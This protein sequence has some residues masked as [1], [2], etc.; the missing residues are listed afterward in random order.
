[1]LRAVEC[2]FALRKPGQWH[3]QKVNHPQPVAFMLALAICRLASIAGFFAHFQSGQF[4]AC[5]LVRVLFSKLLSVHVVVGLAVRRKRAWPSSAWL[6]AASASRR[7]FRCALSLSP[8]NAGIVGFAPLRL[9]NSDFC[10][11]NHIA[12]W[13]AFGLA[14]AGCS[15]MPSSTVRI[16]VSVRVCRQILRSIA[17]H[18]RADIDVRII[19]AG[20]RVCA[21]M[22]FPVCV[23]SLYPHVRL[24][25]LAWYSYRVF[26]LKLRGRR[27]PLFVSYFQ[28]VVLRLMPLRLLS[29]RFAA[30]RLDELTWKDNIDALSKRMPNIRV[31]HSLNSLIN[32]TLSVIRASL[33]CEFASLCWLMLP[34]APWR[35]AMTGGCLILEFERWACTMLIPGDLR[36]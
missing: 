26:I 31:T 13:S 32:W 33:P 6:L 1:V 25:A 35:D 23:S 11:M 18:N 5:V 24:S 27:P 19:F 30:E 12:R 17:Y 29:F 36:A 28:P 7:W 21:P 10:D 8:S 22:L 3:E 4:F 2:K 16:A 34:G 15:V 20:L 9:S 14:C